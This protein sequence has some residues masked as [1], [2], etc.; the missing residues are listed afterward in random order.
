MKDPTT[1]NFFSLYF[2]CTAAVFAVTFWRVQLLKLL[3][4]ATRRVL[5]PF[6]RCQKWTDTWLTTSIRTINQQ[7][8][9]P[10]AQFGQS[11]SSLNRFN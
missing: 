11:F 8:G 2:F 7:S 9:I 4:F 5:R 3:L 10:Y 1:L 6:K